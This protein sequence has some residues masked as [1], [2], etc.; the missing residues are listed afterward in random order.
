MNTNFLLQL[1]QHLYEKITS[2]FP[3]KILY[4]PQKFPKPSGKWEMNKERRIDSL[5][6]I[7]YPSDELCMLEFFVLCGKFKK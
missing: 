2:F 1:D 6:E 7:H 3:L 5:S 4:M